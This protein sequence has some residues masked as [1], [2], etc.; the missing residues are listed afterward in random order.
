MT[1]TDTNRPLV[2]IALSVH[3]VQHTQRWYADVF[4]LAESGGTHAFI[5]LLGSEDVQGVP[6]ATSVCWW[7][8][9]GKP[10]FQME[11][12]E[13]SKPEPKPVPADWTPADIG[14]TTVGFHV[15]DFDATLERLARRHTPLLT[16]PM[17]EPGARRVCVKDPN[18]VLLELLEADVARPGM[19]P[20]PATPAVARFVTLSV[21]DLVAARNTWVDVMGL[22]EVADPIHEPEHEALWG[23]EEAKRDSFVVRAGDALIEVVQYLDPAGEPWPEGYHIS[24]I[25][26][27]N[28]ALGTDTREE[29]D[30]LVEKGRPFGIT[31][32]STKDTIVSKWW[33]ASYVNDPMGFSIELL[34]HG[35]KGK[36]YP[37]DPMNLLE[38]GFTAK[39]PPVKRAVATATSK[40]SIE[41]VWAVLVDHEEMAEWAPFKSTTVVREGDRDGVG[42]VRRLSGGPLGMGLTETIAAVEAPYRLEY[43]AKGV[44]GQSR[45][46]GFVTLDRAGDG[47]TRIT[48]EAQY[49]SLLPGS[50]PIT[51][52]MLRTLSAALARA[53][54]VAHG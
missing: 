17:G 29:L 25:G 41:E 8:L 36:R 33:Y 15:A 18:G 45:Y 9:D 26:I 42:L 6:G 1:T 38:L 44:P 22:P 43:R 11:F 24:D 50:V 2:Q 23:L 16:E 7:M 52:A 34:W 31:P 30:A 13:F 35:S 21:P 20:R 4:G 37:V 51:G 46:H 28:I 3:D 32:N 27:L 10:G 39:K 54:E 40:A 49:R 19:A 14:Y 53:A 47:G 5:P 48:W 12:F